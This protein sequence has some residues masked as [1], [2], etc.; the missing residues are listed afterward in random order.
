MGPALRRISRVILACLVVLNPL[1]GAFAGLMTSVPGN[2][3]A[4]QLTTHGHSGHHSP[5]QTDQAADQC[6]RCLDNGCCDKAIC[7]VGHCTSCM[8]S[9]VSPGFDLHFAASATMCVV[10]DRTP[11]RSSPF[12]L[13][14]P[15][16][17]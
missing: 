3:P 4:T 7:G 5:N 12:L 11:T 15:P 17:T 14:R 2:D 9:L 6:D 1:Q 10:G 16:R 8:P 13:F